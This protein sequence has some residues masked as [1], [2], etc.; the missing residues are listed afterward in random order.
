MDAA[1]LWG[2]LSA[3]DRE[4]IERHCALLRPSPPDDV[5]ASILRC[6]QPDRWGRVRLRGD[7]WLGR[8][9]RPEHQLRVIIRA[10]AADGQLKTLGSL[11]LRWQML[12][13]STDLLADLVGVHDLQIVAGG[14]PLPAL[15][16]FS[17]MPALTRLK[18]SGPAM[19]SDLGGLAGCRQLQSLSLSGAR[20]LTDLSTLSTLSTLEQLDLSRCPRIETLQP[21][22]GLR[23]LAS[24]DLAGCGR[25]DLSPL[26]RLPVLSRL[27]LANN[28]IDDPAPLS[29]LRLRP[30][31]SDGEVLRYTA[32]DF[33]AFYGC[34]Q[35]LRTARRVSLRGRWELTDLSPLE[36][37]SR[38]EILEVS[39]CRRLREV[40]PV[41]LM[42]KLRLLDLRGCPHLAQPPVR[43]LL[44]WRSEVRV[45]QH[46]LAAALAAKPSP[47]AQ[48]ARWLERL[49]GLPPLTREEEDLDALADRIRGLLSAADP[50]SAA[51]GVEMLWTLREPMLLDRLGWGVSLSAEGEIIIEGAH[52]AIFRHGRRLSMALH[53]LALTGRLQ[54]AE[55][56][57]I[58][59]QRHSVADL[60]PLAHAPSLRDLELRDWRLPA[61]LPTLG[62]LSQLQRLHLHHS[63]FIDER[64]MD[65]L[66]ALTGLRELGLHGAW[67][68][69]PQAL[70]RLSVLPKLR[71]LQLQGCHLLP[72]TMQ[73]IHT[74]SAVAALLAEALSL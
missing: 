2:G 55:R 13:G 36:D 37:A 72:R 8:W 22:S 38:V 27:G 24:L 59:D 70:A 39:R 20:V 17:V 54:Q 31:G 7:D 30:P 58:G 43:P 15:P 11:R 65:S 69:K 12:A 45:Y 52:R 42:P 41:A 61:E 14:P 9:V 44:E 46:T 50:D 1:A 10:L 63:A 64:S 56:L 49:R 60:A 71:T 25:H 34:G 53:L 74:G 66:C 32:R 57:R 40:W 18:V 28:P 3:P 47:T 4:T 6:V 19:L 23:A 29:G 62:R 67:R 35:S 21:L 16:D 73:G 48:E 5:T 33:S 68:M 51:Q 26:S